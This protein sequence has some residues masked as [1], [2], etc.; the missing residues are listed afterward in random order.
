M[1]REEAE[2]VRGVAEVLISKRLD[3]AERLSQL[4]LKREDFLQAVQRLL[5][6]GDE[7]P[8][9]K[10]LRPVVAGEVAAVAVLSPDGLPL[11]VT[12]NADLQ[13]LGPVVLPK[14]ELR[15]RSRTGRAEIHLLRPL[16]GRRGFLDVVVSLDPSWVDEVRQL[17]GHWVALMKGGKVWVSGEGTGEGPTAVLPLTVGEEAFALRVQVEAS[18][19]GRMNDFSLRMAFLVAGGILLLSL[20]GATWASGRISAP[21]ERL[22][23]MAKEVANGNYSLA[24]L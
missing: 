22:A 3:T 17:T 20:L 21:L 10:M 4:L 1:L 15:V 5:S 23:R 2:R 14:S 16:P 9:R 8:C 12:G 13:A 11:H 6:S 7:A 19:I 24:Q 18:A